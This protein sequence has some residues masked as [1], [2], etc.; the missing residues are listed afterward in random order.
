MKFSESW[1]RSVYSPALDSDALGHVL[2]MAGLE[3]EQAERVAPAFSGIVVGEVVAVEVHPNA[4]RLRVCRVDVGGEVLQIVCG[5]PNVRV[6][7]RVPCATVGAQLP[8]MKVEKVTM[9]G[10]DSFGMLCSQRELGLGDDHSGLMDLG[11][12]S[13][14]GEDV[15]RALDLDDTVFTLKLTPNRGDCL[16]IHGLAREVAALMGETVTLPTTAPVPAVHDERREIRL[17]A[18]EACPRYCGRVIAGVDAKSSTPAWMVRRLQRSGVRPISAVVDITNYVML[19][20]GQPLHAFDLR[21]LQGGI[22][23]RFA[24]AGEN[25]KL[26]D[27]RELALADAH[28]IIADESRPLALAGVM[29]G[30]ASGVSD[31]TTTVFLESAYFSPE[32]VAVASRGLE[33][34]SDAAHRFE[35]GVDFELA[36]RVIERATELILQICSGRPGPVV[37]ALGSLP[38]R[39]S[40]E[41]RPE[42]VRSVIGVD[43][44]SE[45]ITALL[46]RLGIKVEQGGSQLSAT[47]PSFRFDLNIEVDYIEEVARVHGYDNIPPT[48]PSGRPPMLT[49]AES[50]HSVEQIKRAL[51]RRDYFEVVTFSFV[52]RQLDEDFAGCTDS[53]ALTNPI[54]SQLSVMRKTLLGSLVECVRFNVAHKQYRVRIFEVAGCYGRESGGFTQ[55]ERIAGLACGAALPEQWGDGGRDVDFHDV[56]GDLEAVFGGRRLTFI[57]GKHPAFHPGQTAQIL[58][59][60][61]SAGW[62]GALHPRWLQKY[63]LPAAAVGFELDAAV[64]RAVQLPAYRQVSRFPPVR[65]DLAIVVENA[66]PVARIREEILLSGAPLATDATLFDVY[67]GKGVPEGRKS[68][69]FR[70]LFQ[71]TEKTLTDQQVEALVQKIIKNLQEKQGGTL[72]L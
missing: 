18:G 2:T 34:N 72:R 47:P 41:V 8:E 40:I 4:D 22:R 70:V 66:V 52:D 21:N 38:L 54:A 17:E 7:M 65:R 46:Q 59:D 20:T 28:M 55:T 45:A 24:R 3:V 63:E 25:L 60:G 11:S 32:A 50:E 71:D 67:R 51:A 16:S 62:V 43:M 58:C 23:V 15:R 69:A 68:L 5:A 10:V 36:P 27:G 57:R 1:L 30:D 13:V 6:G 9:R 31:D 64:M 33:I 14:V 39:A 44:P 42:R 19:E 48:L 29:G 56:R 49:S 12:I 35:R 26:L 61:Q 37:E 53:V